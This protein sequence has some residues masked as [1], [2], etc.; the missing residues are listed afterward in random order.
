MQIVINIM[1]VVAVCV[2]IYYFYLHEKDSKCIYDLEVMLDNEKYTSKMLR[3][4]IDNVEKEKLEI[5][6]DADQKIQVAMITAENKIKAKLH[7]EVFEVPNY[8]SVT[9]L[10]NKIK[11]I[12]QPTKTNNID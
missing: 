6:K 1:F 3:E 9:N 4:K 8:N 2:A 5:L 12:L 7:E 11:S 10:E